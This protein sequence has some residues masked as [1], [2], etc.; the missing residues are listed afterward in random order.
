MSSYADAIASAISSD[1]LDPFFKHES[2]VRESVKTIRLQ[3]SGALLMA[4]TIASTSSWLIC[5]SLPFAVT[6]IYDLYVHPS[7]A[8]P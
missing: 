5:L 7:A 8:N 6:A 1:S 3:F 4:H 2:A